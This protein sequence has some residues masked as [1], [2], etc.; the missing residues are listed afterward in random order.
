MPS[1]EFNIETMTDSSKPLSGKTAL[2]TGG[3]R[4]IG[5]AICLELASRGADIC[6]NYLRNHSAARAVETELTTLGIEAMRHRANLADDGAIQS[7]VD[8]VIERFG[9]ID[10]L[11]NNAASGVM[12]SSRELSEKHWDWTQSINAKAPWRLAAL[13]SAHMPRG[14]RVINISSPGSNRVLPQYFPVG[15]SKATLDAVTRY[16][17]IDLSDQGIAVN[18]VSASFVETDALDA[19]PDEL[20]IREVALRATP[21]GRTVTPEDVA[22]VV[23][24]LCSS[25]AE[26]IRGQV[27]AVDG[28]EMLMHR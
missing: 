11:V 15:V 9:K 13:A 14:S 21:A 24:M 7:L 19:F 2:V 27:I 16:M 12:R 17:A 23:A 25:D 18:A 5:R 4:G 3:S 6:F 26:M 20:G 28:G 22:K 1:G 8:A 10:I